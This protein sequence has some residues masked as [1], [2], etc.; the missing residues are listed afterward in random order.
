MIQPRPYS[1]YLDGIHAALARH[2]DLIQTMLAAEKSF[3]CSNSIQTTS[4]ILVDYAAKV[5]GSHLGLLATF[6]D[7]GVLRIH[8]FHGIDGKEASLGEILNLALGAHEKNGYVELVP[9]ASLLGEVPRT[10]GPLLLNQPLSHTPSDR[11]PDGLPR[12][13]NLLMV[14]IIG[15]NRLIGQLAV[16]N[17]EGDYQ[18]EHQDMLTALCCL[19]NRLFICAE[20]AAQKTSLELRLQASQKLEAVGRLAAGVAHDFNNILTGVLGYVE[21]LQTE[22]LTPQGR[23]DLER[24]R[25]LG[26]RAAGLVGQLLDFTRKRK[27]PRR[28]LNLQGVVQSA[29]SATR[30]TLPAN[31]QLLSDLTSRPCCVAGNASQLDQMIKNLIVNATDAMPQGGD[32][33]VRLEEGTAPEDQESG[34]FGWAKLTVSDSGTGIEDED[35]PHIFEPFFT[36]KKVGK[37]SGL[38]LPQVYGIVKQHGGE[39]DVVSRPGRGTTFVLRLPLSLC[40]PSEETS[41]PTEEVAL[42]GLTI[43]LVEDQSHVRKVIQRMLERLGMEVICTS[44]GEEAMSLDAPVTARVDLVLSDVVM[45]RAGGDAVLAHWRSQSPGTPVILMSGYALDREREVLENKASAWLQKPIDPRSL[46]ETLRG[47]LRVPSLEESRP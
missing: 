24:L 37:G 32:L 4:Q 22:D 18:T 2:P 26:E 5:T 34:E 6:E 8:A 36:T 27:V 45:P 7:S 10:G 19:T 23:S 16:A 11:V 44:N 31:V 38:G 14:P 47:V 40:P 42:K 25:C 33:V 46:E 35:L 3:F 12:F 43:L 39:I 30:P 9:G 13:R 20:R 29:V 1:E 15:H 28:T 17:R 41:C 21:F